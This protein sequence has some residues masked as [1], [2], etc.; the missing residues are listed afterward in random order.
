MDIIYDVVEMAHA[1][2]IFMPTIA[3]FAYIGSLYVKVFLL[4]E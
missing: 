3:L 2:I 1:F 4:G